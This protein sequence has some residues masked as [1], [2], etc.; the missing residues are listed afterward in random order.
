MVKQKVEKRF[1]LVL[2]EDANGVTEVTSDVLEII[3]QYA[4]QEVEGVASIKAKNS[5]RLKN[6]FTNTKSKGVEIIRDGEEIEIIVHVYLVYGV[7]VPKT[8]L[9]IQENVKSQITL[10]TDIQVS[11][12]N[13][14]IQGI[15]PEKTVNIDPDKMFD[16]S[17]SEV[18]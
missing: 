6:A 4:T 3:A 8:A 17:E 5:E 13:V 14:N 18:N 15:V 10:M 7:S 12:V 9:K 1:N 11:N 16:D 2:N